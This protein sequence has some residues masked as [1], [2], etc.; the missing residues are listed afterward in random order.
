M[1]G[2]SQ[3]KKQTY[4]AFDLLELRMLSA[5]PGFDVLDVLDPAAAGCTSVSI[6]R[7]GISRVSIRRFGITRVSI[8]RCD[9][10]R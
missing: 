6:R 8:R 2:N 5:L 1:E 7:Y 4:H 3:R 10:E 9:I